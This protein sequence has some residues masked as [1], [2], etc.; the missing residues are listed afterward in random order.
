MVRLAEAFRIK[1]G[2]LSGLAPS[3]S[4][5]GGGGAIFEKGLLDAGAGGGIGIPSPLDGGGAGKLGLG[6]DGAAGID[7]ELDVVFFSRASQAPP[8]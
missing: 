5:G 3:S 2:T 4:D 8:C 6:N 7:S 1:S